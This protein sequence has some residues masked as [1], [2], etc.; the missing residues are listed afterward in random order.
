MNLAPIIL[1]VYNRRE[2]ASQTIHALQK[3][4]LSRDSD[5]VIFS[6]AAKN[7]DAVPKVE[8]VRAYIRD[9]S[10]FKSIQI[11]ER[12]E[13]YGLAR[14]IVDGVTTIV[15]RYGRVIVLEDDIVTSPYFLRYM[16][17]ALRIYA[18][19]ERVISIHGYVYPVKG[20]LPETFFLRGADCWGWATWK[21]GW[22]LFEPDGGKLMQD[23]KRKKLTRR[24]DLNGAYPFTRMLD[25]QIHGKNNSWAIRWYASAL[26]QSKFTLYPGRSLVQNIGT[27]GSGTHCVDTSFF[28][29]DATTMPIQIERIPVEESST[30]LGEF[31]RYLKSQHPG[32]VARA[33]SAMRDVLRRI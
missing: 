2:H 5:L 23:L 11:L 28:T 10:G 13:N 15:N 7:K 4:D 33:C 8:E 3:N 26:S 24:F 1:F 32:L 29:T 22:D 19:D 18:D 6:D 21:R 25:E 17:D 31:E 30:A 16:N 9:I 12:A 14:N 20:L 27:D